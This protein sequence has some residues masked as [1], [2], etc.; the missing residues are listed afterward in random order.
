MKKPLEEFNSRLKLAEE[1]S[2]ELED[3]AIESTQSEKQKDKSMKKN[4]QSYKDLWDIIRCTNM[5]TIRVTKR[6][7]RKE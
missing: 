6:R 5:P 1:R 3:R 4:E 2:N 7:E